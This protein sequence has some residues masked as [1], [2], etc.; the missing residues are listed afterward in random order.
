VLRKANFL[1]VFL[2]DTHKILSG[3]YKQQIRKTFNSCK[4]ILGTEYPNRKYDSNWP[5]KVLIAEK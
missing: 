4:E 1:L 5:I 3:T 2:A